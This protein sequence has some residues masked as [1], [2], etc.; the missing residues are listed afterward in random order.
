MFIKI[1]G[2]G[3]VIIATYSISVFLLN[4]KR[5]RIICLEYM[6]YVFETITYE[7]NYTLNLLPDILTSISDNYSKYYSSELNNWIINLTKQLNSNELNNNFMEIWNSCCD[8][9][10]NYELTLEDIDIIKKMGLFMTYRN[11][12]N[13]QNIMNKNIRIINTHINNLKEKYK[14]QSYLYGKLGVL[15]GIGLVIVLL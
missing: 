14:Q 5:K 15:A 8:D 13:F 2:V 7:S 1:T 12:N 3:A 4:N 6:Q 11:N 9:L 10:V